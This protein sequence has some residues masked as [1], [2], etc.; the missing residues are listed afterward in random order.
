M[1]ETENKLFPQRT[2][3]KFQVNPS[4]EEQNSMTKE[5]KVVQEKKILVKKKKFSLKE[6]CG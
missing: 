5:R 6:Y 2:K 1:C 3:T 4:E